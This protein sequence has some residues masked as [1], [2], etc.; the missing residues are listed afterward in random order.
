MTEPIRVLD[1]SEPLP[2]VTE[3]DLAPVRRIL[4]K[5]L[6]VQ[7]PEL[8]DLLKTPNDLITEVMVG[9]GDDHV[10]SHYETMLREQRFDAWE[11][12]E[13]Q[14]RASLSNWVYRGKLVR[15]DRWKAY[16]RADI[17]TKV[18][19]TVLSNEGAQ[20]KL[21][22]EIN[23]MQQAET[24]MQSPV[25]IPIPEDVKFYVWRRDN[26]QCVNCGSRE[27]IE[28]DHIIPLAKGGS[29]TTRNIQILCERRN[30][31]KRDSI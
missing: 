24:L 25:R 15:V 22:Q 5:K 28:F 10:I 29:N 13:A 4:R 31:A 9:R 23:L 26:G 2:P 20:A 27:L 12:Q 16:S 1:R 7:I 19:H 6:E 3:Q 30:R 17:C 8:T 11:Q 21:K 18:V 14:R